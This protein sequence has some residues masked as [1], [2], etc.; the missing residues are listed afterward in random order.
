MTSK[1]TIIILMGV[2]GTGKSTIGHLL[3]DQLDI[4]FFDGDDFHPKANIDKMSNGIPLDD[5]DR[6]GWLLRL[7][8]LALEH[9][10]QGAIIACSALKKAYRKLL[11]NKMEGQMAFIHLTGSFDLIKSRLEKRKSH[12]M[13]SALLQSQFDTL[14]TP[15][16]AL[17]VSITSSPQEIVANILEYLASN[18]NQ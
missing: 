2:S 6:E 4:P 5:H 16:S 1:Y 10:L 14:E 8:E 17:E 18:N 11:K 12:Y 3:S 7:N 15:S 9:K 13:T